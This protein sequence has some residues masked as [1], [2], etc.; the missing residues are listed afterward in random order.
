MS[1]KVKCNFN[2]LLGGGKIRIIHSVHQTNLVDQK[3]AAIT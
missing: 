1:V 2:L 3:L